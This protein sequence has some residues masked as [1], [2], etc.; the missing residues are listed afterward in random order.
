MS[1]WRGLL[2]FNNDPPPAASRRRK[3]LALP[4][5]PRGLKLGRE[6][7][8]GLMGLFARRLFRFWNNAR[9]C[10]T[11][12]E[13]KQGPSRCVSCCKEEE[14]TGEKATVFV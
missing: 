11:F 2:R 8:V 4:C 3:D 12:A 7:D 13:H 9:R 14:E 1:E 5:R 10:V 6:P